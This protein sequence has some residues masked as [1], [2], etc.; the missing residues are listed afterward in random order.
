M[1]APV[2]VRD[3]FHRLQEELGEEDAGITFENGPG[4]LD[5]IDV[6]VHR[7][8]DSSDVTVFTT[9][10]MSVESMPSRDGRTGGRAELRLFRRGHVEPQDEGLIAMCLAN[11]AAYP[12]TLGRALGWGE[13]IAFPDDVP[14]F[15]G[16]RRAFLAGPWTDEQTDSIQTSTEAVRVV[17][18]VPISESERVQALA[19]RPEAFFS[20]L[21]DARD[22]FT[23]PNP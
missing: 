22:V 14:T 20:D 8:A 6:M 19:L 23:P 4:P 13:V 16:C 15:P 1:P 3:V 5:R 2:I 7:A 9:V 18:V 11:L 17:N 10:G 12:W 21:L